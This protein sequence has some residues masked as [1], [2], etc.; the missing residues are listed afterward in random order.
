MFVAETRILI[1]MIMIVD[2]DD[3]HHI[4]DFANVADVDVS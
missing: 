1:M 3:I 4:D 2:L